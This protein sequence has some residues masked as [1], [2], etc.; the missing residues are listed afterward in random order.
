[1]A[2]FEVITEAERNQHL[3]PRA[4]SNSRMYGKAAADQPRPLFHTQQAQT[5]FA[6]N[7][8]R[9][10]KAKVPD[11]KTDASRTSREHYLRPAGSGMVH[12]V[13]Q[14]FLYDSIEAQRYV[15]REAVGDSGG[16]EM[17]LQRCLFTQVC[18]EPPQGGDETE[19]FET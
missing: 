1:M 12:N 2:G 16:L 18:A 17:K 11:R 5:L 7:L 19:E 8:R 6:S 4:F 9:E 3:D 10:P 13:S 14:S 15:G